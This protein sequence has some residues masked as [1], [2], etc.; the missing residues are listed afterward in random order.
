MW[1]EYSAASVCELP[2]GL[3]LEDG[4]WLR[5]ARLRS[6]SGRE[7]DWLA[8]HPGTPSALAVTRLLGACL[9]WQDD[10]APRYDLARRLLVGD[11]DYLM[12]QLRRMTLGER[13]SAVLTCPACMAR[14]DVDFGVGDVPAEWH[15]QKETTYALTFER[16]DEP[17]RTAR[18]RLPTGADQEA[19][20]GLD[21][22]RAVEALLA[23]CLIDDGSA[24]LSPAEQT[25]LIDTMEEQAPRLDL[26]LDLTCPECSH[27]FV[28]PFDTTAFFLEEI[29][30][31]GRQLLREVHALA[32]YYHWSEAD[33][34]SL[35]RER[36]RA[37]LT[38]LSDSLRQG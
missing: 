12:L 31:N 8:Q 32:F 36:R 35:T 28:A 27:V 4:H 38:L 22:E 33:I 2:G 17:A 16:S 11:R 30:I 20:L 14:M 15:P 9:A 24:A 37:Y 6:L 25:M 34:L 10:A 18:F 26:D 3:A 5:A 7:E 29:R 23:R 1:D 19:V 21:R 13:I